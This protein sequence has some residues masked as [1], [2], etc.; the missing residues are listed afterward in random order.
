MIS[1]EK[2]LSDPKELRLSHRDINPYNLLFDGN[3]YYLVDWE[4]SAQDNLY[5]DLATCV[6]YY[7]YDNADTARYFLEQYFGKE[8]SQEQEDKLRLMRVA[9][10]IYLGACFL[11]MDSE[12]KQKVLSN[13][14]INQ[15]PSYAEY[16][17][18]IGNSKNLAEPLVQ[19]EYG[20]VCFKKVRSL[21][22]HPNHTGFDD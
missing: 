14:E 1:F 11:S 8:L 12:S 16:M 5:L 7:F 19:Q 6:N 20:F 13:E 2:I 3:S 4:A 17:K 10:F 21:M 9:A 15:L 22:Q 18:L